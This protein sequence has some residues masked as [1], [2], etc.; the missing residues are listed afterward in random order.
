MKIP[1]AVPLLI[2]A[3]AAGCPP[4]GTGSEGPTELRIANRS[5]IAF[6]SVRVALEDRDVTAAPL[7]PGEATDYVTVSLLYRY[8]LVQVWFGEQ[9]VNLQPIDYVGEYPLG[10]G[11]YTYALDIGGGDHPYLVLTLES[12]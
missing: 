4:R 12:E 5:S 11:R 9:F 6:D 7:A 10:G 1:F 2:L 8:A 3:L